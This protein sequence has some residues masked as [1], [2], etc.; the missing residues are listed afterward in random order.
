MSIKTDINFF[1]VVR[2]ETNDLKII[3]DERLQITPKANNR[4]QS[5]SLLHFDKIVSEQTSN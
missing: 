3:D 2:A 1:Y 4:R 5:T